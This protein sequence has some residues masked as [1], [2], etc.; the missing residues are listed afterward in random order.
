MV[1]RGYPSDGCEILFKQSLLAVFF[2]ISTVVCPLPPADVD[3]ES[4]TCNL[5]FP[6][7]SGPGTR[8]SCFIPILGDELEEADETISVAGSTV[9]TVLPFTTTVVITDAEDTGEE[10]LV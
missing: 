5:T 3:Y 1:L 10:G 7:G 8:R 9:T 2:C 4:T 6:S